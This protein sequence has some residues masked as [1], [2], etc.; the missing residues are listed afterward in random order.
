MGGAF[1]ETNPHSLCEYGPVPFSSQNMDQV[2]VSR[3]AGDDL[4]EKGWKKALYVLTHF[5]PFSFVYLL[6]TQNF[7]GAHGPLHLIEV[8]RRDTNEKSQNKTDGKEK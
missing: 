3:P 2:L 7:H 8:I 1:R 4:G 6:E 5:L